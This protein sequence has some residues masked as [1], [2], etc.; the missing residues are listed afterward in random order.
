MHNRIGDTLGSEKNFWKEMHNLGLIPKTSV[1][2]RSFMLEELNKHISSIAI[3]TLE[4]PAKSHTSISAAALDGFCFTEVSEN[5]ALLAVSHFKSQA[6][7]ED[8]IP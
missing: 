6:R 7:E 5:D 3:S 4:D 8:E 2:L 1:A